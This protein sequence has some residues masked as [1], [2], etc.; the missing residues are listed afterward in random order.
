MSSIRILPLVLGLLAPAGAGAQA[1]AV[2]SS[3]VD[4]AAT[5]GVRMGRA[6]RLAVGPMRAIAE[7]ARLGRRPQAHEGRDAGARS[8]AAGRAQASAAPTNASA[9]DV[10]A[11]APAGAA[12]ATGPTAAIVAIIQFPADLGPTLAQPAD[13]LA[14]LPPSALAVA[15]PA[16]DALGTLPWPDE[17]RPPA[18]ATSP[19][20]RLAQRS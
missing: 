15:P 14:P 2:P 5:D 1:V 6:Q 16:L 4:A 17:L 7:A 11:A 10:S 3:A 12:V 20:P 8:L 9:G 13:R 18:P 19:L